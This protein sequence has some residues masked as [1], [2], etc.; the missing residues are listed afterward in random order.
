MH[1]VL[2]AYQGLRDEGFIELRRGRGAIVSATARSYSA[3]ATGVATLV[4]DARTHDVSL[5]A[6]TALIR[7]EYQ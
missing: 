3:L 6:L 4:A 1:T 7:K 5:A 2:R